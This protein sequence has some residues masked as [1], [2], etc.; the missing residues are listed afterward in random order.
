MRL[1]RK[2]GLRPRG[3][4]SLNRRAQRRFALNGKSAARRGAIKSR[5]RLP[6]GEPRS[7]SRSIFTWIN[8]VAVVEERQP[9]E[10]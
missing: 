8:G 6:F 2:R 4:G 1:A 5:S 10:Q 7:P 9:T 3:S